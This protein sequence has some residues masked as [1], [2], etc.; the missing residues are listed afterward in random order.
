[1][2]QSLKF[3]QGCIIADW[4]RN[5]VINMK[6]RTFTITL[7]ITAAVWLLSA[8]ILTGCGNKEISD[9]NTNSVENK[10]LNGSKEN[11]ETETGSLYASMEEIRKAVVEVLGDNYWPDKQLGKEELET[12]TGIKSNMY[13]D[14]LAERMNVETDIDMM[15]IIKAET[16]NLSTLETLLNEYRDSLLIK[17]KDRP[18]ELGKVSASRI[19]IIDSYICFVQ[20]GADTT[21]AVQVGDE[22]VIKLCQQE[23]ERA[24]DIIEK[25]ILE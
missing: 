23:N 19:E 2:R 6:I 8:P 18:Q 12:E 14:I 3:V 9:S 21:A 4:E 17:Y 16:E 1:M 10:N 11:A 20:L 25:T 22:E 13:D 24:I 5:M 7:I 15:L